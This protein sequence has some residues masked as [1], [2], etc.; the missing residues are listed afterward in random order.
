MLYLPQ[1]SR[2]QLTFGGPFPQKISELLLEVNCRVQEKREMLRSLLDLQKTLSYWPLGLKGPLLCSTSVGGDP[3]ARP[4]HHSLHYPKELSEKP[5]S[6]CPMLLA[7]GQ[8]EK[9]PV[10]TT[11]GKGFS[12]AQRGSILSVPQWNLAS[13]QW[14]LAIGTKF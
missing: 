7:H 5:N 1:Q 9:W 13:S 2:A 8:V 6:Y 11:V 12:W 10:P 4:H 3:Q 14:W